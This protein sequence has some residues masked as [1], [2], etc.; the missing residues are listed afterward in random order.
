MSR[1]SIAA[2]SRRGRRLIWIAIDTLLAAVVG[3]R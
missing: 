2:A 1:R 3:R